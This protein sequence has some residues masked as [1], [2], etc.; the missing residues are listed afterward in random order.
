[1]IAGRRSNKKMPTVSAR[2]GD[3]FLSGRIATPWLRL[4]SGPPFGGA[5]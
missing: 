5:N 4:V 2:L 3:R 1:M